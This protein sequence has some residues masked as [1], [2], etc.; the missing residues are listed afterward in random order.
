M[1]VETALQRE[2]DRQVPTVYAPSPTPPTNTTKRL[3]VHHTWQLWHLSAYAEAEQIPKH[4]K[5]F[6]VRALEKY[7]RS[8]AGQKLSL[9]AE[10]VLRV[11]I[12]VAGPKDSRRYA[13]GRLCVA[14]YG[15]YKHLAKLMNG[16]HTATVKRGVAELVGAG[17]VLRTR[18]YGRNSVTVIEIPNVDATNGAEKHQPTGQ[19]STNDGGISAPTNTPQHHPHEKAAAVVTQTHAGAAVAECENPP[20]MAAAAAAKVSA[21]QGEEETPEQSARLQALVRHGVTGKKLATLAAMPEL[22][23]ATIDSTF[24][25]DKSRGKGTGISILNLEAAAAARR[26]KVDD[27][28]S[29][30]TPDDAAPPRRTLDQAKGIF[31]QQYTAQRNPPEFVAECLREFDASTGQSSQGITTPEFYHWF[32]ETRRAGNRS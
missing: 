4:E 11:M 14:M 28:A 13:D 12:D 6:K 17:L 15:G 21:S 10:K 29:N 24:C 1:S 20:A 16:V 30:A 27:A 26:C 3:P 8:E 19:K 5:G 2:Q 22:D 9:R 7:L 25:A 23:A 18:V 32:A 31:R